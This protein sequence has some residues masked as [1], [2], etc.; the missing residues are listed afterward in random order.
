MLS[1][2]CSFQ[3]C[4]PW[5]GLCSLHVVMG[6]ASNIPFPAG[7]TRRK[8]ASLVVPTKFPRMTWH[9]CASPVLA[10]VSCPFSRSGKWDWS[11]YEVGLFLQEKDAARQG[12]EHSVSVDCLSSPPRL[13]QNW[14]A[15]TAKDL[16]PF[17]MLFSEDELSSVATKVPL[18]FHPWKVEGI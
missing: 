14:T 7:D 17:L 5:W 6:M 4:A 16:G 9:P 18:V 2:V 10:W 11:R 3:L 15:E 8:R 12:Q 13:P 1:G